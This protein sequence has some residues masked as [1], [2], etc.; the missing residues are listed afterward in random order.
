M[1][2][3]E[4]SWLASPRAPVLL[5]LGTI[6]F[7]IATSALGWSIPLNNDVS[8]QYWVARQLRNGAMF[9]RDI[10]DVNPPLWFWEAIPISALADR[11]GV[12]ASHLAVVAAMARAAIALALMG[13]LLPRQ[14]PRILPGLAI[15]LCILPLHDFAE[16]EHLLLFGALPYA[17]LAAK[18]RDGAAVPRALAVAVGCFAAYAFAL[19]PH[20]ALVPLALEVWLAW[21]LKRRWRPIRAET[22]MLAAG[23]L[24]YAAAMLVFASDYASRM[25]PLALSAYGA[26]SPPFSALFLR[27]AWSISWFVAVPALLIGRHQLSTQARAAVVTTVALGLCYVLQ[28]KGFPYHAMAVSAALSWALWLLVMSGAPLVAGLLRRPLAVLA[29]G[30]IAATIAMLG[31]FTPSRLG[32]VTAAAEALPEGSTVAVIS[33]HSWHAFP[34]VEQ[35][36]FVWPLRDIALWTLPLI[37]REGEG[38]SITVR[39]RAIRKQT[40]DALADDLWCL[41]PDAILF[42]D[43][44]LSPALEGFSFD[45]QDFVRSDPRISELLKHYHLS[46]TDQGGALYRRRSAL[47]PQG[48]SCRKILT[49]PAFD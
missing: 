13:L 9:Y 8:W 4:K 33:A 26:F 41:P 34:L 3:E 10:S 24:L 32:R 29:L 20:F 43:P 39:G 17:A 28:G 45:Y 38:A 21:G 46:I 40:L 42:D 12:D 11:I 27:Q 37:A 16:R 44:G 23:A 30:A 5:A 36:R 18:R 25:L 15:I 31:L 48:L 6:A 22:T 49:R 14:A 7:A 1:Q 19:K 2:S 47:R 35:R